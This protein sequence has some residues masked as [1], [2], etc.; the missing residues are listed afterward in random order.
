M[1]FTSILDC[2]KIIRKSSKM[3]EIIAVLLVLILK[4]S[5][6]QYEWIKYDKIDEI[7]EKINEITAD[8]CA[9]KQRNELQ[10]PDDI[11]YHLP[12]IEL[13]KKSLILQN[14][15][16]LLH[17]RNIAHKNAVLYSYLLQNVFDFDQ[18]GLFYYYLHAAADVTGARGY[19]N[20]SGIV[21]DSDKAYAHWYKNYFNKT[22]PR[23]GPSAWRDDDFYDAFN[24][25][26]DWTNQ[27]IRVVDLGAGRNSMYTSKYFKGNDWY[28]SWLPDPSPTDL[29]NGKVVHYFQL[30]TAKSVGQFDENAKPSQFYGPPGAEDNPGP[31][32]WT[33]P[34][35]DCGRSNK[36]IISSVS[37]IVD[38]YPRHTEYRNVQSYR[39]LASA[40][41]SID[42]IMM[43]INQCDNFN[44]GQDQTSATVNYFAG[45][46]KCKPTTRCEPLNGFGFRR[47]GYQCLCQPG[48][49]YPPYQNGPFKGELIEKS[50]KEEYQS[51]FDC[52]KVD[53]KL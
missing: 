25:R 7:F 14:R 49:R 32:K 1:I 22:I 10:L 53:C 39:Y 30:T 40:V 34:Y 38:V 5:H 52:I 6:C 37:P 26:N 42:F 51:N 19:L 4:L 41:A 15:T 35:F 23:F 29:Y 24:W 27:T 31:T 36:W 48:Y 28:F 18:P 45:T 47:G 13:L 46:H 44:L 3:K 17:T 9:Q 43:D 11:I 12:S 21:Y 16:Q 20:A 8:N 2:L 50:T 33:T